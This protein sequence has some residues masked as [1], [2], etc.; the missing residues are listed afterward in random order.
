VHHRTPVILGGDL[1]DVWGSLGKRYLLPA[2]F[3]RAGKL[4][5]T[6]PA[7]LP[8]RPLDGI[9]LRGDLHSRH[10]AVPT[11]RLARQ[12]SDHLPLVADLD[13]SPFVVR[14]QDG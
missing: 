9:F 1:N 6:F 8:L 7:A 14:D 13:L 4:I 2:G 10:V 12:A 3:S 11:S 5:N